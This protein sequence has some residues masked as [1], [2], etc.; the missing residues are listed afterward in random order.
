[1]Q[2]VPLKQLVAELGPV[3]VGKMLGVSHQGITKA[4]EAGREIFVTVLPD[5]KA[6]GKEL[7]D[8]PIVKKKA[9]PD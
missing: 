1:M 4:V 7:S 3:R 9:A 2:G 6:E 5:G 8:F